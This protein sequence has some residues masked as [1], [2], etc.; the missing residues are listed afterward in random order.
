M[1]RREFI[2]LLGG[3][4]VAWPL[5]ASAQQ[6]TLPVVGFLG[7]ASAEPSAGFLAMFRSGLEE[8]TGYV[9]G[10][11]VTIPR[12]DEEAPWD[13]RL[14]GGEKQRLAFA[15][16]LPLSMPRQA[17]RS[18]RVGSLPPR[19]AAI[20]SSKKKSSSRRDD[21]Q[22]MH[23][24]YPPQKSEIALEQRLCGTGNP[25]HKFSLR[26]VTFGLSF[27]FNSWHRTPN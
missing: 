21:P 22:R 26:Y 12:L 1:R 13:Q 6:P 18:V 10:Q 3:A 27:R 8:T 25:A 20:W 16:A 7:S 15:E 11:N 2:T 19:S 17:G 5:T 4:A 23:S 9:E 24:R 14:S